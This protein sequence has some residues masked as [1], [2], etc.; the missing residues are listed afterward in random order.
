MLELKSGLFLMLHVPLAAVVVTGV[1]GGI[2]AFGKK[3]NGDLA[4]AKE[5]SLGACK[6]KPL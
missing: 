3:A 1:D 5:G 2:T 6:T 4:K